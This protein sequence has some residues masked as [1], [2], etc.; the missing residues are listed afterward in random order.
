MF[1]H[2]LVP[3]DGSS[4]AESVIPVVGALANCLKA[5]ITLIHII[6]AN[7]PETVHGQHH[8]S[9]EMEACQY[10]EQ[11]A[12]GLRKDGL[13]IETHVHTSCVEDLAKS[14][15]DHAKEIDHDLIVMCTHGESGW[16]DRF[17]GSIAQQ[18]IG[19][20][21]LPVLLLHPIED[22]VGINHSRSFS[23]FL[24][25]LDG[26]ED[27]EAGV[28]KSLELARELKAGL[29]LLTVVET[30]S[31]LS[32]SEAATGMLLPTATSIM[33]DLEEEDA[34]ER[35]EMMATDLR[36]KGFSVSLDVHRGDPVEWIVKDSYNHEC[37]LIVLG[38]H[39]KSGI[40]AFWAGSSAPRIPG[41]VKTAILLFPV[42]KS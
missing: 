10:L 6:E 2:I 37:D 26:N 9:N 34:R 27:H 23:K 4:L 28:K 13:L 29:H 25:A 14:L 8:I 5:K 1:K 30:Y 39:G 41:L 42:H 22:K 20:G 32:G 40:N 11:I 33:L 18:V 3:L 19:L 24:L 16:K 17:I 38:T 7:P 12:S 21:A 36:T 15:V 31:T 35:L